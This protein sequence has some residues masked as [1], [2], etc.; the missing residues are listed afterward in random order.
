MFYRVKPEGK[1]EAERTVERER[2]DRVH[3]SHTSDTRPRSPPRDSRRE[4]WARD[5]NRDR[6]VRSDD[7]GHRREPVRVHTRLFK[8]IFEFFVQ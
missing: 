2:F 5:D 8:A 3:S 6:L 7:R 4:S 1:T